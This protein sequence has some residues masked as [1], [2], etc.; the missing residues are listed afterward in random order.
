MSNLLVGRAALKRV[1]GKSASVGCSCPT[2]SSLKE[3]GFQTV[4][5]YA[6]GKKAAMATGRWLQRCTLQA[7]SPGT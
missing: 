4:I 7:W 5:W 1:A 3:S 2:A 6:A